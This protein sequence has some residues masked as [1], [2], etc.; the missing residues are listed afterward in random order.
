MDPSVRQGAQE[1]TLPTH[2]GARGEDPTLTRTRAPSANLALLAPL[3]VLL[4]SLVLLAGLSAP[5]W[6]FP[7]DDACRDWVRQQTPDEQV[8]EGNE[9]QAGEDVDADGCIGVLAA[10]LRHG[11]EGDQATRAVNVER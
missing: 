1:P 6:A 9:A 3:A 7:A 5:A 2:E 4:V 8:R 10:E 11:R